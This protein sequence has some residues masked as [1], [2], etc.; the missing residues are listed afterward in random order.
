MEETKEGLD[1]FVELKDWRVIKDMAYKQV[2]KNLTPEDKVILVFTVIGIIQLAA[3]S[4]VAGV[5]ADSISGIAFT[6][7]IL[8]FLT[9]FVYYKATRSPTQ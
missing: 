5:W 2:W 3:Y 9:S 4:I 7:S 6:V 1:D 8:S